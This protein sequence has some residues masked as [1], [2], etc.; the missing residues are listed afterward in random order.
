MLHLPWDAVGIFRLRPNRFLGIVDITNPT[1]SSRVK[2]H[3]HDPGRLT[4]LLYP[5]NKVLLKRARGNHRATKWDLVAG[6]CNSHWVLVHSNYHRAIAEAII[7]SKDLTP[8]GQVVEVNP[9]ATYGHSRLDFLLIDREGK[10]IWVEVKGCTL[11]VGRVALFPDAPTKRGGK[12]LRTLISLRKTGLR[13][14]L[15]ILIFREGVDLFAPNEKTDPQFHSLFY[16]ALRLGV[17]VYPILLKYRGGMVYYQGRVPILGSSPSQ[18]ELC[19]RSK[20]SSKR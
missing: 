17:E 14:S 16:Q 1:T 18:N 3:I 5:G 15:L 8:F 13:S 7:R 6:R 9:E 20:L 12:H 10:E 11:A 2:V 4:E 19:E